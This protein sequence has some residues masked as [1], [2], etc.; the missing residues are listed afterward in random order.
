M[1]KNNNKNIMSREVIKDKKKKD[2]KLN[3]NKILVVGAMAF[4]GLVLLVRF[5]IYTYFLPLM[6]NVYNENTNLQFINKMQGL[7][8]LDYYGGEKDNKLPSN[9][10]QRYS[11]EKDKITFKNRGSHNSPGGICLG[12]AIFEKLN[13]TNKL[14]DISININ[15]EEIKFKNSLEL[16][17][18][19]MNEEDIKSVYKDWGGS[20]V[21]YLSTKGEMKNKTVEDLYNVDIRQETAQNNNEQE[22]L[23]DFNDEV[24]DKEVADILNAIN[25][26]KVHPKNSGLKE[27]CIEPY[28]YSSK[29]KASEGVT[30]ALLFTKI[31]NK[32]TPEM[33]IEMIDADEPAIIMITSPKSGHAVMGYGYEYIDD[34]TFKVYVS[35][36]N[37]PL[38]RRLEHGSDEIEKYNND[39]RNNMFILF[40]RD[41]RGKWE[42]I[43]NPKINDNY[44]YQGKYNSYVPDTL[45]LIM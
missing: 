1:W 33:V 7:I 21:N 11:L 8:D 6:V 2:K 31:V 14:Q 23:Q 5:P 43:Y 27:I 24:C 35:D 36:S 22:K 44:I 40:K 39:I 12:F 13:Y 30:S 20:D 38:L 26:F 15:G 18:I 42:Y 17:K 34:R 16:G 25:Y 32:F 41:D 28:V 3:P 10:L 4:L 29:Q 9:K 37:M 19:V 45:M